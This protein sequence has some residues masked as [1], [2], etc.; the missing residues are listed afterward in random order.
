MKSDEAFLL[1]K[2]AV[3]P[4]YCAHENPKETSYQRE[5][6]LII[7]P[8]RYRMI[9]RLSEHEFST[10][11]TAEQLQ[12]GIVRIVKGIRKGTDHHGELASEADLLKNLVHPG[13]PKVLDAFE[14]EEFTYLVEEYVPGESLGAILK[15]RLLS[16]NELLSVLISIGSII[17]YLHTREQP[18]VYMDLKPE[19]IILTPQHEVYLIDFGSAGYADA[20]KPALFT[21]HRF[22]AASEGGVRMHPS[23]DIYA[24][25]KLTEY[26]AGRSTISPGTAKK[27]KRISEVCTR[28]R[29]QVSIAS[30][31]IYVKMLTSLHA[32]DVKPS[33]KRKR[34]KASGRAVSIGVF[35]LSRGVGTT[36][37][38]VA[39]SNLLGG[40]KEYTTVC[41]EENESGDIAVL[42][43]RFAEEG[44]SYNGVY[45]NLFPDEYS[46]EVIDLGCELRTALPI[47]RRC[48][49][50][51]LVGS[52]APW[53][54]DVSGTVTRMMERL[55]GDKGLCLVIRTAGKEK[56]RRMQGVGIP[57]FT[58]PYIPDVFDPGRETQKVFEGVMK[59]SRG[60]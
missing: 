4:L 53:R 19:N 8:D 22:Y 10:V 1:A 31:D 39:L 42:A 56:S 57:V 26:L 46:Y 6:R 54:C 32:K 36:T 44:S 20:N 58:L 37:V 12:L 35:G 15:H 52:G 48:D 2:I 28:R 30:A 17:E 38:A 18:I 29:G 51:I 13:I 45:Y 3:Y 43:E 40:Q 27:L 14:D 49:I 23:S 33:V 11:W 16:E 25:G 24:L 21:N 34:K 5:R 9:D 59:L 41:R 47:L 7:L 60:I 55:E 50:K